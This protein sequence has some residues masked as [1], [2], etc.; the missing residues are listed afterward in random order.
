MR[1]L[2]S[3]R[4]GWFLC[5]WLGLGGCSPDC[6]KGSTRQGSACVPAN[7]AAVADGTQ[8]SPSLGSDKNKDA[9]PGAGKAQPTAS[10]V[11]G[12]GGVS[13]AHGG[14]G[15]AAVGGALPNSA[16]TTA[17]PSGGNGSPGG[18]S[19][20]PAGGQSGAT[21]PPKTGPCTGS[22]GQNTCDDL[23]LLQCDAN[24]DIAMQEAC[25][26]AINCQIGLVAGKCAVCNPGTFMC[27]GTTLNKCGDAG[28]YTLADTCDSAA[29]C[30]EAAGACTDMVCTPNTN[31]CAA[32]GSLQTCS[33]D[34]A[35]FDTTL[36]CPNTCDAKNGKCFDCMPGTKSCQGDTLLSCSSA[37]MQVSS[38]CGGATPRCLT[39][40]CVACLDSTDCVQT[41]ECVPTVCDTD[42]HSCVASS[43]KPAGSPCGTNMV[44]NDLGI[45]SS[46][47][48]G[49][50][51]LGENCDPKASE[52]ANAGDRCDAALC[53]ISDKV[54]TE[55]SSSVC[56][57]NA[58]ACWPGAAWACAA[59]TLECTRA[60]SGPG[61]DSCV[62]SSFHG[63]CESF[64]YMGTTL[65]GCFITCPSGSINCPP[66][67]VC[68][69]VPDAPDFHFCGLQP[70]PTMTTTPAP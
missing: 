10:G 40:K 61:D 44:C 28:Q 13:A 57:A 24:G 17:P 52:W 26:S 11:A 64:A 31:S 51:D 30:R 58:N 9:G 60:C 55:S 14:S 32:N 63:S 43:A 25:S 67:M 33:A 4:L 18:V 1:N 29:L 6:P 56:S 68:T 70:Y 45:C 19:S 8:T 37:G 66:P 5:V 49:K 69:S 65:T 50:V 42:L 7:D 36:P 41:N 3:C 35:K 39:N 54:Y 20:N 59:F 62:T 22:P 23:T 16:G 46:C 34:G 48:N 12:R 47:G 38:A 21:P 53:R 2:S 27:D 15:S